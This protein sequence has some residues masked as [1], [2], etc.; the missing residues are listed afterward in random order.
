MLN[1]TQGKEPRAEKNAVRKKVL[2]R[3]WSSP[4]FWGK[5]GEPYRPRFT[6]LVPTCLD[7]EPGGPEPAGR[8]GENHDRMVL[9]HEKDL[10][11]IMISQQYIRA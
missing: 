6:R 8:C 11:E 2:V 5:L 9:L 3:I 7:H 4:I 1:C 10:F